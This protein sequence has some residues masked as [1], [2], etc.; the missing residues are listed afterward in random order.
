MFTFFICNLLIEIFL[1]EIS[2]FNDKDKYDVFKACYA[3]PRLGSLLTYN[4]KVY[5]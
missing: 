2:V 4:R 5:N 1:S 3:S